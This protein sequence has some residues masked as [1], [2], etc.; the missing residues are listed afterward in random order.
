MRELTTS[1][2]LDI[3]DAAAA[4]SPARQALALLRAASPDAAPEELAALSIGARDARLLSLREWFFGPR[5]VG[6]TACPVCG[7]QLECAFEVEAVRAPQS[8]IT[9]PAE[10][11]GLRYRLPDSTDLEAI[12]H[13]PDADTALQQRSE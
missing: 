4:W 11:D 1:D 2:L 3:W 10:I 9:F 8:E 12:G 7:E 5:V 13:A 6:R